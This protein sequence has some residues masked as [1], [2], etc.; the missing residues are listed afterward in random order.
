MSEYIRLPLTVDQKRLIEEAATLDLADVAAWIRPILLE[1]ARKR[2]A[3]EG[4]PP[5]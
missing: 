2:I 1:A 3:K 5:R 4:K